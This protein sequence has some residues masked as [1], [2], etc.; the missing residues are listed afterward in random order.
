[1]GG[2]GSLETLRSEILKQAREQ[3]LAILDRAQRVAERDLE[4]A[5]E[6]ASEIKRQQR[7]KVQPT[8]DME[9]KKIIAAAEMESRKKLLQKKEELVSRLF[10][11]A[12]SKL[13]E[14]RGSSLYIDIIYRSVENGIVSIGNDLIVE[15]SQ[16][17]RDIFTQ[18]LMSSIRSRV[19]ERF[20]PDIDLQFR[21]VGDDISAGV[22]IRS[23]DGKVIMDNSFSSLLRRLKEDLKGEICEILLQE[24]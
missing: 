9:K 1:M 4:Y 21:G 19:M 11:E 16:K 2:V 12:E 20:G 15:F 22:V 18:E 7:A 13:E 8:L 5:H 3:S 23:K 14:I 17:D 6:E 24:P 10:A